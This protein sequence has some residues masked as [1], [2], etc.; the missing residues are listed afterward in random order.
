MKNKYGSYFWKDPAFLKQIREGLGKTQ[1]QLASESGLTQSVIAN[2]ESGRSNLSSVDNALA[3]YRAL[4]ATES[5]RQESGNATKAYRALLEIQVYSHQ[6]YLFRVEQEI[7][8]L[9]R[10]RAAYAGWLAEF[11]AERA[12]LDKKHGGKK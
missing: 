11:E 10:K 8:S 9:Q 5:F 7:E 2:Y 6:E 3:I 12:N 1:E 4:S